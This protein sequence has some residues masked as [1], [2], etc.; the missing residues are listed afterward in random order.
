M[1]SV[2]RLKINEVVRGKDICVALEGCLN[3]IEEAGGSIMQVV[4]HSS[5]PGKTIYT[6]I[7]RERKKK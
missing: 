2:Y 4:S 5:E 3:E 6:I 7:Y 1:I